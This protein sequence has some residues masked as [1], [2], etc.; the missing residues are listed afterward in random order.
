[1]LS[2][3]GKRGRRRIVGTCRGIGGLDGIYRRIGVIGG[4]G[5]IGGIRGIACIPKTIDNISKRS[6]EQANSSGYTE[7]AGDQKKATQK[8]ANKLNYTH[9]I[10]NANN[11][12]VRVCVRER[13]DY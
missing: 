5:G 8:K 3:G 10:D 11:S 2:I 13:S 4:N 9:S 1:M 6:P 12:S 7:K